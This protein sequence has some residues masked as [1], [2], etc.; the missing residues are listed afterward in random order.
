MVLK[1]IVPVTIC[2]LLSCE[3]EEVIK[4]DV[5]EYEKKMVINGFISA[6]DGVFVTVFKSLPPL[7]M[8]ADTYDVKV[9]SVNVKLLA[10]NTPLF[11]LKETKPGYFVSP[12]TFIAKPSIGYKLEITANDFPNAVSGVQY[13]PVTPQIDSVFYFKEGYL[14]FI[15]LKFCDNDLNKNY[16]YFKKYIYLPEGA[17]EE[18]Y[19]PTNPYYKLFN[20]GGII[21]DDLFNGSCYEIKNLINAT[22]FDSILVTLYTLSDDLVNYLKGLDEWDYSHDDMWQEVHVTVYSN[23]NGGY[24]IFASYAKESIVL[25]LTDD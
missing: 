12:D 11:S 14:D 9:D 15:Q 18:F 13:L 22:S 25:K 5:I 7:S 19:N 1:I 24:G 16:Y 3:T 6:G 23:I 17:D 20:P 10:G 4:Y 2:L 8:P 21:E